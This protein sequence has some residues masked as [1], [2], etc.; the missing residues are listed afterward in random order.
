MLQAGSVILSIWSGINFLLACLILTLILFLKRDAPILIMVFEESEIPKLEPRVISAINVLAILYNSC[1]VAISV[2][3][4]FVIWSSLITGQSW[5]FWALLIT[6]G[7][8][9]LM[10]FIAFSAIGN[11]RWQVNI[12]LS[13]LYVLGIGLVGFSL[14]SH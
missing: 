4:L 11:Q 9:Q 2:L 6:I 8:V 5:A 10:G 7:F 3:V 1:A 14:F 13:A 12:V